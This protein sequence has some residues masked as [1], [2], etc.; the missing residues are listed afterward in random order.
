MKYVLHLSGCR[1]YSTLSSWQPEALEKFSCE[2]TGANMPH[3]TGI[4]IFSF[5]TKWLTMLTQID[6]SR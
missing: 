1:L 4:V 3:E 5:Q 6:Q 2:R